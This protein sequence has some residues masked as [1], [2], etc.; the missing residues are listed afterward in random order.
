V[1]NSFCPTETTIMK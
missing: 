1:K